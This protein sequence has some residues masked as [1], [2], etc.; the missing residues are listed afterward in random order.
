MKLKKILVTLSL[1]LVL[2]APAMSSAASIL[3]QDI[4][5][6]ANC[7]KTNPCTL[8]TFIALGVSVANFILGIVG[9]LT[10]LMFVFGGLMWI[11]SG[12]SSDKVQKGKD[13][14]LGSV[15]GLLIVFSSYLII[16]F[17]T[18][19]LGGTFHAS[20]PP[21]TITSTTSTTTGTECE[22]PR[23]DGHCYLDTTMCDTSPT[24]REISAKLGCGD[25]KHCCYKSKTQEKTQCADDKCVATVCGAG[26]KFDTTNFYCVDPLK[27]CCVPE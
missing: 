23:Y 4:I 3:S 16:K 2:L 11:L 18:E 25:G 20:P 14:I 27:N 7:S 17:T 1:A 21:D 12:G 6:A 9:A 5:N 22:S 19:T 15:V 24:G 8:N 10:L 13:I 26:E